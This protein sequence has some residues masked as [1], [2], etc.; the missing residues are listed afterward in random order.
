MQVAQYRFGGADHCVIERGL[1]RSALP[2]R[3][4]AAR[5][6]RHGPFYLPVRRLTAG[7]ALLPR[8]ECAL[9]YRTGV[10]SFDTRP[11]V[12]DRVDVAVQDGIATIHDLHGP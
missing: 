1:S 9:A 8:F 2:A 6:Q 7:K 10:R 12:V 4:P 11:A 5:L 3:R